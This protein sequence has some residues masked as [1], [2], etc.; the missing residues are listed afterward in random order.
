MFVT[1]R[2]T[3]TNTVMPQP[4]SDFL[5]TEKIF[6]CCNRQQIQTKLIYCRL[7]PFDNILQRM[8]KRRSVHILN[9]C[10][11]NLQNVLVHSVLITTVFTFDIQY[12]SHSKRTGDWIICKYHII[13]YNMICIF[14]FF[15]FYCTQGRDDWVVRVT[16]LWLKGRKVVGSNPSVAKSNGQWWNL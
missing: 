3:D 8:H 5:P 15:L 14:D 9:T 16:R 6:N 13:S 12:F 10:I 7:A 2:D 1:R 4:E 11:I